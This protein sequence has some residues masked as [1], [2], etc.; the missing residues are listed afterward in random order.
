MQRGY[1]PSGAS[2]VREAT[3]GDLHDFLRGVHGDG[4]GCPGGLYA[5]LSVQ[6]LTGFTLAGRDADGAV[7]AIGG[8]CCGDPALPAQAWLVARP[9]SRAFPARL[10]AARRMLKLLADGPHRDR[11]ICALVRSEAGNR[12]AR[13]LG[14]RRVLRRVPGRQG[15]L[16]LYGENEDERDRQQSVR[17]Q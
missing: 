12:M 3:L 16:W 7:I 9:G 4:N 5:H 15:E 14:F 17:G 13:A 8:V 11:G 6:V 1:Q 10:L 2:S